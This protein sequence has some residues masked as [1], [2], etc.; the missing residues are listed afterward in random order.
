[1]FLNGAR[2]Q[3][4]RFIGGPR[5]TNRCAKVAKH[6]DPAFRHDFV[7]NLMN[8]CQHASNTAGDGFIRHGTIGDGEMG[9]FNKPMTSKLEENVVIPGSRAAIERPI[10][11][12]PDNMPDLRPAFA[13]RS[14]QDLG[15][16]LGPGDGNV[17]IIVELDVMRPPPKNMGKTI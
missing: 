7:R 2:G 16:V 12:R 3:K 9:F 10:D 15:R 5:L 1:M 8:G 14:T 13:S 11:E 17:R 4:T 6:L